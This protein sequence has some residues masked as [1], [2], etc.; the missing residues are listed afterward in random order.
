[1]VPVWVAWWALSHASATPPAD[2]APLSPDDLAL[3]EDLLAVT[4]T[5]PWPAPDPHRRLPSSRTTE[6]LERSFRE[7]QERA[8]ISSVGPFGRLDL[9]SER[10]EGFFVEPMA[11]GWLEL[12]PEVVGDARLTRGAPVARAALDGV[13]LFAAGR[14]PGPTFAEAWLT[15]RTAGRSTRGAARGA[16]HPGGWSMGLAAAGEGSSDL[17]VRGR[18]G[19]SAFSE[20]QGDQRARGSG[21]GFVGWRR[22]PV[23][24]RG[25]GAVDGRQDAAD[26]P[27]PQDI[28]RSLAG[29]QL[30]FGGDPE[31]SGSSSGISLRG[32][33][34]TADYELDGASV[35]ARA[36]VLQVAGRL[37][38]G[39]GWALRSDGIGTVGDVDDVGVRRIEAGGGFELER[40]RWQMR[41]TAGGLRHEAAD[42]R[43]NGWTGRLRMRWGGDRFMEAE[44]RKG[45]DGLGSLPSPRG[46]GTVPRRSVWGSAGL[47][48]QGSRGFVR[49]HG[50]GFWLRPE[51]M[52]GAS[53]WMVRSDGGVR[54]FDDVR[55][56]GA[57]AYVGS[58]ADFRPA[59]GPEFDL[60]GFFG[61]FSLRWDPEGGL[62][63]VHAGG[64][65]DSPGNERDFLRVGGMAGLALGGGFWARVA[66]ENAVDSALPPELIRGQGFRP[67]IDV[68][69]GISWRA[70]AGPRS[71]TDRPSS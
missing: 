41:A 19:G 64:R 3:L 52:D 12:P 34:Q 67:G 63:E 53:T 38:L 30:Q 16:W 69:I 35:R 45:R 61:R 22:G 25:V 50:G 66:I 48:A 51:G 42:T 56:L 13:D 20:S 46:F 17:R 23:R 71:T 65:A 68:G 29:L 57:L 44:V 36:A 31:P 24:I 43:V 39:R 9:R 47:G 11:G 21:L 59:G 4:S 26:R 62:V 40:G 14:A 55:L 70:E 6:G 58:L 1:V 27:G 5:A 54:L 7:A 10:L 18:S 37:K 32:S 49:L 33:R 60:E 8:P 15:T 2:E 28:L